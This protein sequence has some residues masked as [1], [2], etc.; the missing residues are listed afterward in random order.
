MQ[1]N[2]S[3]IRDTLKHLRKEQE[4]LM[5][6]TS[7]EQFQK[8]NDMLDSFIDDYQRQDQQAALDDMQKA[9]QLRDDYVKVSKF[10]KSLL[11]MKQDHILDNVISSNNTAVVDD[12]D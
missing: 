2:E 12:D 5:N 9:I 10:L 4:Q 7:P 1:E 6:Q 11:K 8:V 3:K